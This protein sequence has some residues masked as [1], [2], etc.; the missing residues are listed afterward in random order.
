MPDP[1]QVKVPMINLA[2][3]QNL[4]NP[5]GRLFAPA[6]TVRKVASVDSHGNTGETWRRGIDCLYKN[7][8]S[9]KLEKLFK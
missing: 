2:D 8:L 1:R 5:I 7:V 9:S 4:S 6:R 3:P